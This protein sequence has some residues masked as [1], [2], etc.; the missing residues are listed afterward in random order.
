L[1][2]LGP[3]AA[4]W[5]AWCQQHLE[6][7]AGAPVPRRHSTAEA[8][9][10]LARDIGED[11]LAAAEAEAQAPLPPLSPAEALRRIT[12][13]L[14]WRLPWQ[15]EPLPLGKLTV[16][17]ATQLQLAHTA[18]RRQQLQAEYEREARE[19]PLL[20]AGAG[21]MAEPP[22]SL[23]ATQARLWRELRWEKSNLETLWRL[24]VDGVPMQG[25]CH[26]RHLQQEPCGCGG[27]GGTV[28]PTVTPRAHAF[29][30]CP[31]AVAIRGQISAQ[32]STPVTRQQLWLVE[33]PGG[34]EGCVWDVVAPAALTAMEKGRAHLRAIKRAEAAGGGGAP[35][36]IQQAGMPP[37]ARAV[38]RAETGLWATLEGFAALGKPRGKGWRTV[39]PNH[40]FLA[41]VNGQLRCITVEE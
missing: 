8:L 31:V 16:R 38:A 22:T 39:G 4:A 11:W 41:M 10:S 36:A 35:G 17:I 33:P 1:R 37:L 14:G 30:E 20:P 26:L 5:A 32:L 29:W 3:S 24:A 23:P 12:C 7:P 25:N 21:A 13:R 15:K 2:Q 19:E 28:V 40:P 18:K 9:K 27:H 6:T 34:V